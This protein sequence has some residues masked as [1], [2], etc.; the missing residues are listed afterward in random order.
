[1]KHPFEFVAPPRA[2]QL[3]GIFA[4][5]ALLFLGLFQFLDRFLRTRAAPAGIITFELARSQGEAAQIISSWSLNAR[6]DAAFG[7]GLDYLFMP[8]YA[9]ALSFATLLALRRAS[10]WVQ[11]LG[12]WL[13]W[14]V[15]LAVL[16]DALENVGLY[17][18]LQGHLR[19]FPAELVYPLVL[20]KFSLLGLALLYSLALLLLPAAPVLLLLL[21]ACAPSGQPTGTLTPTLLP[22]FTPTLPQTLLP[23]TATQAATFTPLP[24]T[25]AEFNAQTNL[26]TNLQAEPRTDSAALGLLPAGVQLQAL[27]RD[28][29]GAWVQVLTASG[30]G[31]VLAQ[32]LTLPNGLDSLPV[33]TSSALPAQPSPTPT[34]LFAAVTTSQINVR[35]G[36][37]ST[38]DSLGLLEANTPVTLTGVNQTMTW[39][40]IAYPSAP[41]GKAWAAAAYL[42]LDAPAL[43][44]PVFDAQ[45][46]PLGGLAGTTPTPPPQTY[47]AAPED[48][49]SAESPALRLTFSS[50]G[51]RL[52][53]YSSDLSAP[54]GDAADWIEFTLQTVQEGQAAVLYFALDCAG[55]GGAHTEMRQDGLL[56]QDFPG[57]LCG[58]YDVVVRVLGGRPILLKLSADGAASDIRYI[59]YTLTISTQP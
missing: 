51:P 14:G 20:L 25:P 44:L 47:S 43:G 39:Y 46:N 18:A 17:A 11:R 10:G 4:L 58:Q 48:L 28:D 23:P 8:L 6:L 31:W 30:Q 54:F 57:L 26:Q 38:F 21:A 34:A 2:R 50:S 56:A 53:S 45:G 55:N 7:L 13:G 35:R 16:C 32:A 52:F 59:N 24:P 41:D 42:R 19:F 37:A 3:L 36:P 15:W 49:D 5:L 27:G 9:L 22:F 29:S 12:R 40:Q 1:M 33:T